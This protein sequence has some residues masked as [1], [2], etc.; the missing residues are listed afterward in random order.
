MNLG[1]LREA[2]RNLLG[3]PS[4]DL[5]LRPEYLT[6]FINMALAQIAGE[7]DWYWLD[8][9]DATNTATVA[10]QAT[11]NLPSDWKRTRRMTLNGLP[12]RPIRT[13]DGDSYTVYEDMPT[14]PGYAIEGTTFIIYPTPSS[15]VTLSHRYVRSEKMLVQD[16][17]T[18]RMPDHLCYA[19]PLLACVLAQ[20]SV[21]DHTG[22]AEAR[23]QWEDWHKILLDEQRRTQQSPRVRVRDG[24]VPF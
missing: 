18:P 10:N 3:V 1:H 20:Q 16:E 13:E 12:M 21:S 11:Y 5:L 19:V 22:A 17:D 2:T 14:S 6:Q 4:S 9:T 15:A 8:A 23:K 7:R 24:G